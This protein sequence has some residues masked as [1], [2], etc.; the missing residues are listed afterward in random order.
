MPYQF[1]TE[2][3][4]YSDY[5]SGRVFYSLAG[6]PAFPVRLAS[7]IFLRCCH[8]RQDLFGLTDPCHLYD[9]CS[10]AAY[11]LG[12]LGFLHGAAISCVS[13][14]DVD[15]TA[16][17]AARHNLDLLDPVG[18]EQRIAGINRMISLYGKESHRQA[19][20]SALVLQGRSNLPG[21]HKIK[22]DA[23]VSSALDAQAL[24]VHLKDKPVDVV[25]TDV[26]Y[27]QHSQWVHAAANPLGAML[28][29][30]T[31]VLQHTAVIAVVSDKAQKAAHDGYRR[32]EQ[33]QVGKR[34]VVILRLAD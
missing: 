24:T 34:R 16:V 11:H 29:A 7:E 2:S 6:H 30:L 33:F 31:G 5:S 21:G 12:V 26:P 18:M 14:S 20:E 13:A 25:F 32:I 1:V 9:P 3:Q 15:E 17:T 22:T 8:H 23:F 4:D 10:G 28:G 27:G 19:L